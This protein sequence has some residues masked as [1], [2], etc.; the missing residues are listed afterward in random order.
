MIDRRVLTYISGDC[1]S[2][3]IKLDV[4]QEEYVMVNDTKCTGSYEDREICVAGLSSMPTETLAHEYCHSIQ[5]RKKHKVW[6]DSFIQGDIASENI[7]DL[8][9]SGHVEL[10]KKQRD[11]LIGCCIACELECEQMTLELLERLMPEWGAENRER[12]IIDANT[13]LIQWGFTGLW[14]KWTDEKRPWQDQVVRE[15]TP[16]EWK[17]VAAYVHELPKNEIL[18]ERYY[19]IMVSVGGTSDSTGND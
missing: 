13:Y 18:A 1:V 5:D 19:E 10:N 15:H 9:L 17:D 8:W 3:G 4:I 16:K 7:I 2:D 6:T 11:H 14:R 12:Y